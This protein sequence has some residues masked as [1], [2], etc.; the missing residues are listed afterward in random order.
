M[1]PNSITHIFFDMHGTLVDNKR[2]LGD[3]Y[4]DNL[5][6]VMAA[7]YGGNPAQWAD[8][9]RAIT[10]D[11]DSYIADL[12]YGG[13][14]GIADMWEGYF[15]TTRALFRLTNTPEPPKH[16]LTDL[17][18]E[19][20]GL[21][22]E[23]CNALFPE[24]HEVVERLHHGGYTLGVFS[25]ALA[26]HSRG[27]LRGGGIESYFTGAIIGADVVERFVKDREYCLR[28]LRTAGVTADQCLVVDDSL[29]GVRGAADAGMSALLL[30]RDAVPADTRPAHGVLRG[31]LLPLLAVLGIA[32]DI[33]S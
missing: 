25:H 12:D 9:N 6:S 15:R 23:H 18:R 11:W 17:S 1:N 10:R 29:E 32:T 14:D 13:K 22:T 7:R 24:T 5:G 3:C 16:E 28:M 4:A 19:L 30:C 20:P 2:L 26:A 27:L 21:A 31:S 33:S 8:A